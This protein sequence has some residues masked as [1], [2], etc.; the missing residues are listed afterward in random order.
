M[1]RAILLKSF[2]EA[3]NLYIAEV[4]NLIP[5]D[6]EL[7]VKVKNFALNRADILQRQG[8]YPPPLGASEILGL[9][10]G[11]EVI[12]KGKNVTQFEIGDY[13]FGLISGGGY[14]EEALIHEKMAWKLPQNLTLQEATAIPEAFL[15]AYQAL[16]VLGNLQAN[17]NV[18]IHAGGSGVGTACIQLAKTANVQN[19][20]VTASQKKHHKCLELGATHCIDYQKEN[21]LEI[22]ET[23]T[24]KKGVDVLVDFIGAQ[25]FQDNIQVLNTDGRMILL[26]V[27]SGF[28]AESVNLMKIIGKRLTLLGSTLRNRHIEYQI[29]LK[30]DFWTFA[31][32]LFIN[33]QL[34]PVVDSIWNVAKIKEAHLYLENNQNIGKIIMEW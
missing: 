23:K 10:I 11:G 15:T 24:Q 28:Q 20:F 8:K 34:K 2:G 12:K 30:N 27:L 14:A 22:I 19:I 7:V 25:Y 9:E 26:A 21:F 5:N 33:Q 18:L 32:E 1:M 31:E 4:S 13:V 16:F 3:D 17:E 6:Y 29:A